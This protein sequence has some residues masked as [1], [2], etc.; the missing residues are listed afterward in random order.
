MNSNF[1]HEYKI[2][3]AVTFQK[4]G[5]L[6]SVPTTPQAFSHHHNMTLPHCNGVTTL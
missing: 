5:E 2:S 6:L 3:C 4:T 1:K